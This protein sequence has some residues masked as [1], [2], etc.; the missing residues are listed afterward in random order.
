MTIEIA[1]RRTQV[2]VAHKGMH[3]LLILSE[4]D[5]DCARRL[6][7]EYGY[8]P[9][10]ILSISPVE[11]CYRRTV[12]DELVQEV[13]NRMPYSECRSTES[14]LTAVRCIVPQTTKIINQ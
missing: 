10:E 6:A 12:A 1:I 9:T 8:E 2:H 13:V 3:R 4:M 14:M 5:D 11:L 7:H